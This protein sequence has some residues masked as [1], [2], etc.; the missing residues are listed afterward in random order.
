[1]REYRLATRFTSPDTDATLALEA[2]EAQKISSSD[3]LTAVR[4]D[5]LDAYQARLNDSLH[6][7][8][9]AQKN[10][11]KIQAAEYSALAAG[12]FK[13]LEPAFQN[14][15]AQTRVAFMNLEKAP[16]FCCPEATK[17][18]FNLVT[19]KN[20]VLPARLPWWSVLLPLSLR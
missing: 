2:L 19:V 13:I 8:E 6:E 1:M 3:A 11:F 5:F 10:N 16:I 18:P 17:Q 4:A 7:L 9:N 20:T 14:N 12:Y 15:L